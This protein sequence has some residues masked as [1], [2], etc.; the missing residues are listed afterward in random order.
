MNLTGF[1]VDGV[2]RFFFFFFFPLEGRGAG[3]FGIPIHIGIDW[4]DIGIN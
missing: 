1:A 2:I 4:Y 3:V